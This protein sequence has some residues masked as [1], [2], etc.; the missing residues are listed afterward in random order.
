MNALRITAMA[1]ETISIGEN[2]RV[3]AVN[4]KTFDRITNTGARTSANCRGQ[5]MTPEKEIDR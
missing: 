1:T 3:T 5:G 2:T 4:P